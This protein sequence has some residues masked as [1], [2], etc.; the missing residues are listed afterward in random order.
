[1]TVMDMRFFNFILIFIAGFILALCLGFQLPQKEL[2]CSIAIAECNR[3]FVG[4]DNPAIIIVK[5]YPEDQVKMSSGSVKIEKI[6]P[7]K[8][9][10]KCN[11]PGEGSITVEAGSFSKTYSFK[12]KRFQDPM[13]R[14]NTHKD[15]YIDDAAEFKAIKGLKSSNYDFDV[16]KPCQIASYDL[17]LTRKGG[18]IVRLHNIGANYSR[19]V[20]E[21]I[22]QAKSGD[23][24]AFENIKV[25]C[26]G[27]PVHREYGSIGYHIK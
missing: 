1:M 19:E 2:E 15:I 13:V 5:G 26:P 8:Y 21:L 16:C 11:S 7:N 25:R 23:E 14:L 10:L 27:E 4:V 17:V 3:L 24:Y 12:M 20:Q 22:N 18:N 9:N 6:G